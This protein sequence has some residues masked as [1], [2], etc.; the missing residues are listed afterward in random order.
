MR[1]SVAIAV[2]NGERWMPAL[3]DSLARQTTLPA[4]LVVSDDASDDATPELLATFAAR[5]PF[6]VRVERLTSHTGVVEGFMRAAGRCD[7]EAIAFCDADDVWVEHKLERCAA[8]LEC[9]DAKLVM[10]STRVV[11]AELRDLGVS[12]PAIG[13]DRLVPPLGLT[14][15]DVDAPGMAMVFRSELLGVGEFECRP[16]S[17]YGNGKPM[18]HDEW[19]LFVAGVLGPIRLL[20]EPLVLYRQ[21]GANDSGGPPDRRRRLSLRPASGDY[22]RAADHLAGCAA[23]LTAAAAH[24][25]LRRPQLNAGADHYREAAANWTLRSALYRQED[26]RGRARIL[27]RMVGRD[28]YR[29][30]AGGGF[31]RSALGKDV[32]AGLALRVPENGE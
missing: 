16:P 5:A 8:E 13:E 32:V 23:Y 10:H 21:H 29:P 27:R 30:R 20:A 7:G 12:W 17:R 26:R 31:G 6:P 14:S 18:L 24:D 9:T 28:A 4:E 15:L 22:E 2:R 1:I 25:D 11:D 3:L 19:L